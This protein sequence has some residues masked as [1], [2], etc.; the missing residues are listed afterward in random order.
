VSGSTVTL[1]GD[2]AHL[3]SGAASD[4]AFVR[5]V[6]G[7]YVDPA[8]VDT[9]R[10]TPLGKPFLPHSEIHFS[11]SH[12]GARQVIAVARQPIGADLEAILPL[13]DLPGVAALSLTEAEARR[14]AELP[15]P[16]RTRFFYRC[17]TRKEA[18]LKAR[19]EGLRTDP[20]EVDTMAEEGPW[21]WH[22]PWSEPGWA[23]VV[24]AP[25]ALR[26]ECM[27]RFGETR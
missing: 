17:W 9:L 19:G 24:A 1:A 10:R 14:L 2:V 13:P 15:E 7:R 18:C 3:W 25:K 20:R 12:A 6:L 26:I 27:A 4:G 11:V 8:L 23:L 22:E 21:R 5:E 16:A